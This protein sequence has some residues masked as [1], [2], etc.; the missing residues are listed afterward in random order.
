MN[1]MGKD[2]LEYYEIKIML[3]TL[4]ELRNKEKDEQVN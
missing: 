4:N 1:Q 3:D 2:N